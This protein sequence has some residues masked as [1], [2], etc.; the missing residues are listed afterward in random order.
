[1]MVLVLVA[2]MAVVMVMM[3]AM[4]IV[5]AVMVVTVVAIVVCDEGDEYVGVIAM[6]AA[7]VPVFH[8]YFV[9]LVCH[10]DHRCPVATA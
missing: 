1:M 4:M 6:L 10:L 8:L 7:S 5:V 2:V 3:V 9:S